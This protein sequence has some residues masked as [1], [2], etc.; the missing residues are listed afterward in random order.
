MSRPA[1]AGLV[2]GLL[3][4]ALAVGVRVI[5][6]VAAGRWGHAA[7]PLAE[8]A[9]WLPWQ[10]QDNLRSGRSP[11][12]ASLFADGPGSLWAITGNPGPAWLLA[13]LHAVLPAQGAML[14]PLLLLFANAVAGGLYGAR[15]RMPWLGA[16]AA[17]ASWW[18]AGFTLG[19]GAQ[20]LLAPGLLAA[21]IAAS[22][23]RGAVLSALLGAVCAPLPTVALLL[24]AA[25]LRLAL[26]A[27]LGL[28]APALGTWGG[29]GWTGA[30]LGWPAGEAERALPL[31][32]LLALAG[33]LHRGA[34]SRAGGVVAA[35]LLAVALR[36]AG[37]GG[38]E[39]ALPALASA[40]PTAAAL[41]FLLAAGVRL[42][43]SELRA[44][45]RALLGVLLLV[46]LAAP[47]LLGGG[48]LWHPDRPIPASLQALSDTPRSV[49]VHVLPA[50]ENPAG[51]V[52]LVPFHRQVLTRTP[53]LGTS[54]AEPQ[55]ID[56]GQVQLSLRRDRAKLAVILTSPDA[57][58]RS[59]WATKLGPPRDV[60][61]EM[62]VWVWR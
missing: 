5:E 45:G 26:I 21:A 43:A 30:D 12:D 25:E 10:L 42:A 29:V 31:A 59:A 39:F 36:P 61:P 33:L 3:V 48:R 15:H 2:P 38:L 28:F 13:P 40:A 20:V 27:A 4:G 47:V 62:A 19:T 57:V 34:G 50:A 23:P 60:L 52:G 24:G 8:V 44:D 1:S 32:A 55:G 14:G 17:S 53:Q 35:L 49:T 51:G 54:D 22:A 11:L 6:G 46:D 37:P 9:G 56:A 41:A 58:E 7:A 18:A 16:L